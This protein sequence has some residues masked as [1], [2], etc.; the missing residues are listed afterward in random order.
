MNKKEKFL[1][2]LESLSNDNPMIINA[3]KKAFLSINEA[4]AQGR[5]RTIPELIKAKQDKDANGNWIP[6]SGGTETPFKS[7]SGKTL[8][9]CYQ[10]STGKHAYLDVGTDMIL[11]DEEA[12]AAL[13]LY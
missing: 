11:S 3:A 13:G 2:F 5:D 4:D 8:L 12:N 9:Y 10:P 6:A 1:N 7:R